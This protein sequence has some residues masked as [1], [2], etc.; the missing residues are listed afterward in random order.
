MMFSPN[1]TRMD[2]YLSAQ[3]EFTDGSK[4]TFEFPRP[5]ELNFVNKYIHGE[6]FRKIITERIR[7]NDHSFMWQD[8]AKFALKQTMALNG[9]EKL[10]SKVKLFRHWDEVPEVYAQFRPHGAQAP[11][12][13]SYNFYSY[14][15]MQ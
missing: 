9:Y 11:V 8:T 7:K 10:P 3:I 1:P 15:V 5:S 13:Q 6:R 12:Y 14:E 2:S 4:T